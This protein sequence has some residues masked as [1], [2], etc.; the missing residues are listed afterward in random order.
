MKIG[1]SVTKAKIDRLSDEIRMI[2]EKYGDDPKKCE[3]LIL[4]HALLFAVEGHSEI[5]I[6]NYCWKYFEKN[7]NEVMERIP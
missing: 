4:Y 6:H 2:L 3:E 1:E 5:V 7:I